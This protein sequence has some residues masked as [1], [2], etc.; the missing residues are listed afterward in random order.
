MEGL[1]LKMVVA[2]M[3]WAQTAFPPA[4]WMAAMPSSHS[5][6]ASVRAFAQNRPGSA[7]S[8]PGD[9]RVSCPDVKPPRA[10]QAEGHF[11]SSWGLSGIRIGYPDAVT[12]SASSWWA[13]SVPLL[14]GGEQR[15]RF[16]APVG[17]VRPVTKQVDGQEVGRLPQS[18]SA[19]NFPCR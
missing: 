18:C 11:R 19:R 17:L 12:A 8:S 6:V 4:W 9:R 7:A 2:V 1:F 16:A 10:S 13:A 5:D 14:S 15:A 3:R